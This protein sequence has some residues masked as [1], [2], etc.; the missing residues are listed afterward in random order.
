MRYQGWGVAIS[1]MF[2]AMAGV[3]L[4]TLSNVVPLERRALIVDFTVKGEAP[5]P[6]PDAPSEEAVAEMITGKIQPRKVPR[7]VAP[8]AERTEATPERP[9]PLE[10]RGHVEEGKEPVREVPGV[11]E[12][13]RG[14]GPGDEEGPMQSGYGMYQAL[15]GDGRST[16]NTVEEVTEAGRGGDGAL[17]DSKE[18]YLKE[19]FDYIREL[20]QKNL[21]YPRI[22]R[23]M[24]WTG[25]VVVAFTVCKGGYVKDIEVIKGTGFAVLDRNAVETIRQASPFPD[26]PVEAKIIVPIAY[27]LDPE[28]P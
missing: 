11:A 17:P 20:I 25:K 7:T 15:Q 5:A 14:Q 13:E 10:K 21:L 6:E 18:A 2:H 27:R 12:G 23:R 9:V 8:A 28:G 1:V 26:P 24:G 3:V 16:D 4:F 19:H 22:A